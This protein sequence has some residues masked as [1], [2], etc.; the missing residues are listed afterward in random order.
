MADILRFEPLGPPENPEL[1]AVSP[2]RRGRCPDRRA[3]G[4]NLR[5]SDVAGSRQRAVRPRRTAPPQRRSRACCAS[6]TKRLRA[7]TSATNT[8]PISSV[9]RPGRA[10]SRGCRRSSTTTA[11]RT[12]RSAPSA[13]P[14]FGAPAGLHQGGTHFVG[15]SQRQRPLL[16][17]LAAFEPIVHENHQ[18][19][20]GH[21]RDD[22][23]PG[24]IPVGITQPPQNRRFRIRH[25]AA[26]N[27][28]IVPPFRRRPARAGE[29]SRLLRTRQSPTC[30]RRFVTPRTDISAVPTGLHETCNRKPRRTAL[31][32][33]A[34]TNL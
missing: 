8:P 24:L 13:Q 19:G 25:A 17:I 7:I 22:R 3:G 11:R 15:A 4:A 31:L 14:S 32:S 9:S 23:R 20:L 27:S 5:H 1:A 34:W 30:L 2:L 29:P 28:V 16:K 26:H 10:S 12:S 6:S 33:V 18:R 21:S